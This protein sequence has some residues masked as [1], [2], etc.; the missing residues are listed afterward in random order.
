VSARRGE[1][2]GVLEFGFVDPSKE[3]KGWL[4][5]AGCQIVAGRRSSASGWRGRFEVVTDPRL[6][7][8]DINT[9][10]VELLTRLC[11]FLSVDTAAVLLLDS[12]GKFLVAT[13]ARGI[14][15]E[16]LQGVRIP[17][18]KGF[19]GRIATEARPVIIEDIDHSEVL[20]P[21]LRS[22]GVRS[23]LGVPLLDGHGE[24]LGVLH[25]GC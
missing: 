21:I 14:E 6:A 2:L 23:L 16:I 13:A 10:L 9:L 17:L 5:S 18:G 22:S 1:D 25:V 24:V 20:N 11:E 12:S 8:M 19:A 4:W 15:Q 7:G 3:M